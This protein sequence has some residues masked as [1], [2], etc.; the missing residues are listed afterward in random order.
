MQLVGID[1]SFPTLLK[2]VFTISPEHGA[3]KIATLDSET[4]LQQVMLRLNNKL[5]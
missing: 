4:L 1:L 2:I 3:I 5:V